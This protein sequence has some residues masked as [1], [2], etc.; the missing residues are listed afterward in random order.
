MPHL[1][2]ITVPDAPSLD[3]FAKAAC[4]ADWA[5]Y[6]APADRAD[7]ARLHSVIEAFPEGFCLYLMVDEQGRETPVGYTGWYPIPRDVFDRLH[8]RPETLTHRGEIRPL[9]SLSPQGD[10]L[11]LFN[12]SIV[13]ALQKTAHSKTMLE[14]FAR[15]VRSVP[16]KGMAAVTVSPDGARVA[17]RFGLVPRGSMTHDGVP[18][19]VYAFRL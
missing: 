17:Q 14:S 18:E 19:D 13:P 1:K 4:E 3:S 8:D 5:C 2:S 15:C 7:Y 9:P 11:Y 16:H 6:T 10:Y 12:Y